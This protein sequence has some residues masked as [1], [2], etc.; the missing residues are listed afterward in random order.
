MRIPD[1][2]YKRADELTGGPVQPMGMYHTIQT[3][4]ERLLAEEPTAFP[5]PLSTDIV[6]HQLYIL[7]EEKPCITMMHAHNLH[8]M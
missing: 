3:Q 5:D 2:I 8:N 4:H 7:S 1:R 6:M